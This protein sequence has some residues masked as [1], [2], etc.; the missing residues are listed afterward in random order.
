M[1]AFPHGSQDVF[2]HWVHNVGKAL[3]I[4]RD[5]IQGLVGISRLVVQNN[6]LAHFC[7]RQPRYISYAHTS[8]CYH[9]HAVLAKRRKHLSG[10]FDAVSRANPALLPIVHRNPPE[11]S[12]L[13][14]A[15]IHLLSLFDDGSNVW[16]RSGGL[17]SRRRCL[18]RHDQRDKKYEYQQP[19]YGFVH[20]WHHYLTTRSTQE[21][22]CRAARAIQ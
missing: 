15:L 4:G 17:I 19:G 5:F 16:R 6:I 20:G 2:E 12:Q 7:L 11:Y 3:C 14:V 1:D 13:V 10:L 9:H 21:K 22:L 8:Y 18:G